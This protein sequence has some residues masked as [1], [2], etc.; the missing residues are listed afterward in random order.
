MKQPV[1]K[2][3]YN[4]KSAMKVNEA[5]TI[6]LKMNGTQQDSHTSIHAPSR[7]RVAFM[8]V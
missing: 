2:T 3:A 4:T 5:N 6:T 8:L 1:K 7:H